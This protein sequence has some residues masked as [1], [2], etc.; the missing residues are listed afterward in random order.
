MQVRKLFASPTAGEQQRKSAR[1]EEEERE[2]LAKD[3][4]K[5]TRD[6]KQGKT[7]SGRVIDWEPQLVVLAGDK[8]DKAKAC[9]GL[10]SPS[11]GKQANPGSLQFAGRSFFFPFIS[12]FLLFSLL[13]AGPPATS[14][15]FQLP[16][17]KTRR[18]PRTRQIRC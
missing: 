12:L 17:L 3:P 1:K 13:F 7:S 8:R 4:G 16:C 2:A 6:I 5:K 10:Q 11:Q 9:L 18:K 15:S 14:A